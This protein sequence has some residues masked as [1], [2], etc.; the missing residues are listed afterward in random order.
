MK[1]HL[2]HAMGYAIKVVERAV[3]LSMFVL[4]SS[5]WAVAESLYDPT[6]YRSLAGDHKAFRVGDLITVQVYEQSSASTSTDT[7]TQR[8]NGLNFGLSSLSG[9]RQRGGA[10]NQAGNFDGGGTTQR[11]NRLLAT[12]SVSVREVMS[13]GDLRIAGDQLLMVNEEQHKVNLE[14]RVRAQDVS[15]DNV[16][17]ST[18]LADAQ[19]HYV[20]EGD[21]SERQ[22]RSWWRKSLD[23]LGL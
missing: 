6:G 15:A 3:L 10:I 16:V 20:G 12:L 14:G 11:A 8:N 5:P 22:R 4:L 21:L 2:Q 23:W 17:L 18:R 1:A 13:N 9:S 19:I 7:T